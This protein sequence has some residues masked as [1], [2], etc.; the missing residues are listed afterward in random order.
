[1]RLRATMPRMNDHAKI[2]MRMKPLAIAGMMMR[3][4]A[5]I[6]TAGWTRRNHS[7][8]AARAAAFG[9][10][11]LSASAMAS[12]PREQALRADRKDDDH[13]HESQRDRIGGKVS[14]ADLL[15]DT[16]NHRP[17]RGARN[18]AHAADDHH[19]ERSQEK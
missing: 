19:D 17:E 2:W 9:R 13:D 4:A 7:G 5:R 12:A 10:A 6:T 18:R 16:D 3:S 8:C 15:G 11:E 1:M 14:E